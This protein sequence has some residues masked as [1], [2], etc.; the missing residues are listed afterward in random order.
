ML[1]AM[2]L[3]IIVTIAALL[4]IWRSGRFSRRSLWTIGTI[5]AWQLYG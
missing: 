5:L 4:R 1:T 3:A 2:V